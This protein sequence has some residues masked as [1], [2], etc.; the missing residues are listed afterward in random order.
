[1]QRVAARR[2]R[3]VHQG[4]GVQVAQDRV[5]ADVVRLVGLLHVQG[6]AVGV[7]VDGDRLDAQLGAGADDAHGDF[8]T[9]GDQDLS[10]HGSRFFFDK[11]CGKSYYCGLLFIRV[12]RIAAWGRSPATLVERS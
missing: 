7:G 11:N 2:R 10:N 9:V 6:V 3:Q 5:L 8:A 4:V 1:M 12:R